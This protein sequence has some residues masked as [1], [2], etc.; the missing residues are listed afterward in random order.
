MSEKTDNDITRKEL[1][2]LE[3]VFAAELEGRLFQSKSKMAHKLVDNGYLQEVEERHG[4]VI[5][6]GY[7]LTLL[8]NATYC[9]SDRCNVDESEFGK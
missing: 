8:G 9:M 5:C 2:F 7:S 1:L 4:I 3:K 6:R